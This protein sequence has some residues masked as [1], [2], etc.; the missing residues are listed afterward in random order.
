MLGFIPIQ[1]YSSWFDRLAHFQRNGSRLVTQARK[2]FYQAWI[3]WME[4]ATT[5]LSQ[6]Y[7]QHKYYMKLKCMIMSFCLFTVCHIDVTQVCLFRR[8]CARWILHEFPTWNSD[9]TD[10]YIALFLHESFL[11]F[12]VLSTN[13]IL[14]PTRCF[15]FSLIIPEFPVSYCTLGICRFAGPVGCIVLSACQLRYLYSVTV[16]TSFAS[17]FLC[18]LSPDSQHLGPSSKLLQ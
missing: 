3:H 13:T 2:D 7:S 9:L 6:Y 11:F 14:S 12:R 5:E 8:T 15:G 10:Q 18:H 16:D 1:H 4:T 17:A